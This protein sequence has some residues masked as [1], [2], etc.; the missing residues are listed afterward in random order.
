MSKNNTTSVQVFVLTVMM[1]MFIATGSVKADLNDGLVAYYPF[2]TNADDGSGNGNDG[3]LSVSGVTLTCDRFNN[4]DSAFRFNRTEAHI[5]A[6]NNSSLQITGELTISAWI[7][8]SIMGTFDAVVSKDNGSGR[9]YQLWISDSNKAHFTIFKSNGDSSAVSDATIL[10]DT[11]YHL[12]GLHNGTD[13]LLYVNG[14]LQSTTNTGGTIDNDANDLWIG[15]RSDGGVL[16]FDGTIDDVRIYN[17]ALYE[18]EIMQLFNMV[19]VENVSVDIYP[20]HCPNKLKLRVKSHNFKVAILGTQNFQVRTVDKTTIRL[21]GVSPVQ[22]KIKD[23]TAPSSLEPCDCESLPKD[24]YKDLLLKFNSGEIIATLGAVHDGDVKKLSLT[25]KLHDG[26]AIEGFDCVQIHDC[27]L[28][29]TVDLDSI[30]IQGPVKVDE[31]SSCIQYSTMAYYSNGSSRV[32][33]P[34][35]WTVDCPLI[36]KISPAGLLTAYEVDTNV[37][38]T[39][40]ASYTEGGFTSMDMYNITILQLRDIMILG[41]SIARGEGSSD[42]SGFRRLL[43]ILLKNSGYNINFEGSLRNGSLD[44][45]R[46]HEGHNGWFSDQI[47]DNV[48]NWLTNNPSEI[49]L[50]HIGTNDITVGQNPSEVALEVSQIL[51]NIDLYEADNAQDITVLLAL[52]INRDN[53]FSQ[54]GINTTSYNNE[55]LTMAGTRINNGDKIVVVDLEAT[56]NYPADLSD[57]VHPNDVGYEKMS[58]TWFNALDKFLSIQ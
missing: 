24:T 26:T 34:D 38:C 14:V 44:F 39:I 19:N 48:Y 17:R 49:I 4:A 32:V 40:T 16:P 52:I 35:S 58:N 54:L 53:Q 18:S 28:K 13:V 33:A 50:L 11:W 36:A 43:N 7:K 57:S 6:G 37:P 10:A 31:N 56:L 9:S 42:D 29:N 8:R 12:V 30:E 27:S 45:D 2:N 3:K 15:D 1:F 23:V 46:D 41:D 51:N 55:I 21:N 20:R 22:N 5:N 47:R 25:G